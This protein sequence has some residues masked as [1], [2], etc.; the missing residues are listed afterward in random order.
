MSC[1]LDNSSESVFIYFSL[2]RKIC[3]TNFLQI[4]PEAQLQDNSAW[5]NVFNQLNIRS[6]AKVLVIISDNTPEISAV[7]DQM[8][9][10]N[11]IGS[12]YLMFSDGWPATDAAFYNRYQDY[13]KGMT[14]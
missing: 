6:E 7:L 8:I 11:L 5:E 9:K 2:Q 3:I 4:P 12:Y 1:K 14:L 10:R 13:I